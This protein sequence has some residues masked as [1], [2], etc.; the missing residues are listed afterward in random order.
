M[1]NGIRHIDRRR[2][3]PAATS[4]GQLAGEHSFNFALVRGSH[5]APSPEPRG[6]DSD[7]VCSVCVRK[8][9]KR[10]GAMEM[11]RKGC[12]RGV[13]QFRGMRRKPNH[14]EV[15]APIGGASLFVPIYVSI[16]RGNQSAVG[17]KNESLMD[18]A[19][20]E[21]IRIPSPGYPSAGSRGS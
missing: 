14:G 8:F 10:D 3:F 17:R 21:S 5:T 6:P 11:P 12:E 15:F 13:E 1:R 7:G 19:P 20:S 18:S 2:T 4:R 16:W 9:Q